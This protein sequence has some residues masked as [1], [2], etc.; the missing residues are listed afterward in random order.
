ME[1]RVNS[2]ATFRDVRQ[3]FDRAIVKLDRTET[4]DRI[5]SFGDRNT[6]DLPRLKSSAKKPR[7]SA[8]SDL[9]ASLKSRYYARVRFL[10]R[11]R[12]DRE[13]DPLGGAVHRRSSA[14]VC[15]TLKQR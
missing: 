1:L 14:A 5:F 3:E 10:F 11:D 4:R 15:A 9:S 12:P 13:I 8:N 6:G 7:I 2:A